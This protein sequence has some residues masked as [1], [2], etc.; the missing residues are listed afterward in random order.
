MGLQGAALMFIKGDLI[1][2]QSFNFH[3]LIS[4]HACGKD[5]KPLFIIEEWEDLVGDNK[6]SPLCACLSLT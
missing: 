3:D 1:I 5:K 2:P 6:V 4:V